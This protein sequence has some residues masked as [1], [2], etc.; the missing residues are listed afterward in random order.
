M[1]TNIDIIYN[2]LEKLAR[3]F[4]LNRIISGALLFFLFLFFSL[5]SL[6]VT[7]YL[8]YLNVNIKVYLIIAFFLF[9]LSSFILLI[10]I[11]LLKYFHIIKG[12]STLKLNEL[13][14]ETFPE[15][16]DKLINIIELSDAGTNDVYS[17]ELL[18]ASINQKIEEVHYF[19]FNKALNFKSNYRFLYIFAGSLL[20]SL[21]LFF[22]NPSLYKDSTY[23][24][25]NYNKTFVRPLRNEIVLLNK[26]LSIGKGDDFLLSAIIKGLKEGDDVKLLISGKTFQLKNDS[27][28]YFSY[29]FN[30]VNNDV[31]FQFVINKNSS[32]LYKIEILEKPVLTKFSVK[33]VKPGYTGANAEEIDNNTEFRVPVGT[34][35]TVTFNTINTDSVFYGNDSISSSLPK[36]GKNEFLLKE[37]LLTNQSNSLHLKNNNF[38]LPDYLKLSF[39]IIPDEFPTINVVKIVDSLTFTRIYFKGKIMDDYGFKELFFKIKINDK[40]DSSFTIDIS[41]NSSNQDFFYAFDFEK[42]KSVNGNINYYFEVIDND[43]VTGPKSA[44]SEVFSFKFPDSDD[45]N[46]FQNKQ[47]DEIESIFQNNMDLTD[48]L[49]QDLEDLKKKML[50]SDLSEWER[51]EIERNIT[52]TKNNIEKELEKLVQKNAELNNYLES[53]TEQDQKLIEK[54]NQIQELLKD[55]FSDELKKMLDEFNKMMQE[56]NKDKLNK[57]KEKLD[58][59]LDDLS[60]QLDRNLEMLKKLK[61]EQKLD[62]LA[63]DLD[64]LIEKQNSN[65]SELEPK[66]DLDKIGKDQVSQKEK[67]EEAQK[68]YN[69]LEKLNNELEDPLKLYDF[70]NEFDEIKKEFT[71]SIDNLEKGNKKRSKE[72]MQKNSSNMKNLKF[73]LDQMMEALFAEQNQES[74]E[75]LMQILDNLVTFSFNQ[76]E[77]INSSKRKNFSSELF[78][79]QKKLVKD[80]TII[81]DSL[82]SLGKREPA[83]GATFN[84]ELVTIQNNFINIDKDFESN[85]IQN[86]GVYQQKVLTSV[87]NLSLYLSEIIKQLQ[88]K[89]ADS[90]PGNKNCNKPGSK[91]N[92]SSMNTSMKNMQKSLQQQLEKIMKMMKDGEQGR[93][94]QNEMGKAISQQEAMHDLIQKMMNQGNV[95]SNAYET[96][97]QADQLLN[98]VREDILRNN[99]STNT[100]DRQKQIMTRLLEAEKSENE[101]DFEEKRKSNTASDQFMSKTY[102]EKDENKIE[103]N[104]EEKLVKNKL[105]L[106]TFYQ[107][108]FQEYVM[109]L[110]SI[111]GKMYKD[112]V[113][114]K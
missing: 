102:F 81:K 55:V 93:S 2:K 80:F 48:K 52:S 45:I 71:N 19:D 43:V 11:P 88:K 7:E 47:F 92:P 38:Y 12:I 114:N 32:Q 95:G 39:T 84:K 109:K 99:I 35:I 9:L 82:Y 98:K 53:F 70:K 51:K 97:K 54:Q 23:R 65:I 22:M 17:H 110:D 113:N 87:N 14:V 100:I 27:A 3:K 103:I 56:F 18:T 34:M 57:S 72:S 6:L 101:R 16:K 5:F 75:E 58:I 31:F 24:L 79:E 74:L 28:N 1:S 26:S 33:L 64:A 68:N 41:K 89:Q 63:K 21:L 69:E 86:S 66:P 30:N 112:R 96:L 44:I 8:L 94:V 73:N 37:Q 111:N 105:I 42:Y 61:V 15:I 62:L 20:V 13:I 91:P 78:S 49:K 107:E 85:T 10:I 40:A 36:S 46:D 104:Y 60:K 90:K 50:D 59:S 76:E 77:V 108:K 25:I 4:Y 67:L 106:N 83:L 29:K